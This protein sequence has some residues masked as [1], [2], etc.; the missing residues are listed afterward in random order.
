MSESPSES[1]IEKTAS[2]A[3]VISP[4][5]RLNMVAA[6]ALREQLRSQVECGNIA[7]VVDLSGVDF[8]DSAG[9]GALISGLKAARQAGGSLQI[10]RPSTQAKAILKLTTLDRVLELCDPAD[11]DEPA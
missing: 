8:I 2:G 5:G 6:P 1:P 10:A 4:R 11:F 3:V 7:L 9:L